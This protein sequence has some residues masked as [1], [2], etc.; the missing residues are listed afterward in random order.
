MTTCLEH[1]NYKQ[2]IG[3]MITFLAVAL[4]LKVK[5]GGSSTLKRRS[6]KKG[7]EADQCYWMATEPQ[8]RSTKQINLRV[9]PPPDL[10]LEV[11]VM[12]AAVDRQ[13]IYAALGVSEMWV[14]RREEGGG[15][16][17]LAA[18]ELEEGTWR[19]LEHS[20]SFPFL[21]VADL[22]PFVGRIGVD[23]DM[24]VLIDFTGWLRT[25]HRWD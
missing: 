17:A 19:P 15:A 5:H 22:N 4:K 16:G 7:L 24:S 20:W 1:E 2:V 8:M 12:P 14:L 18:Y 13:K 10:V 23:D 9:D 25:V 6:K 21:R 11:D 3:A